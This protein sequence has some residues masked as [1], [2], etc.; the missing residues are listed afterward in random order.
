MKWQKAFDKIKIFLCPIYHFYPK[1]EIAVASDASEYVAVVLHK[2]E[3]DSTKPVAHALRTL[4]VVEKI[5]AR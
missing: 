4:L 5:T 3:D 1:L 2:F